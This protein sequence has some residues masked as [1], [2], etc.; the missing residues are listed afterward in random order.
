QT[1]TGSWNLLLWLTV[2]L[3]LL[4]FVAGLIINANHRIF[5]SKANR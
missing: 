3:T 1:A 5:P 2:G 4:M